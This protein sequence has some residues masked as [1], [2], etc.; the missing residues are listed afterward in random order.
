MQFCVAF[1]SV[2][3]CVCLC[4][5]NYSRNK[6]AVGL[7]DTLAHHVERAFR[8]LFLHLLHSGYVQH[9][10]GG[11]TVRVIAHSLTAERDAAES[12]TDLSFTHLHSIAHDRA[13]RFGYS[14]F[15]HIVCVRGCQLKVT[16]AMPVPFRKLS[17]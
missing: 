1:V 7:F 10:I 4:V 12:S 5:D 9:R 17:A 11:T 2:C 13:F 14:Y 16:R 15:Q 3:V 6:I 8:C